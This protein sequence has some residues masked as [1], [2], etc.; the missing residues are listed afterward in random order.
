MHKVPAANALNSWEMSTVGHP[1]SDVCNLLMQFYTP[2]YA[3]AAPE[4]AKGFLPGRTPGLPTES[5]LLRWYTAVTGYDP[6]PDMSWGMAFNIFKLA[7][8]CQ[9]I[10]ARYARRQASSEKAK[11]H[12]ITRVPLAEFAWELAQQSGGKAK[13]GAKL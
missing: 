2:R 3:G 13:S 7:G 5:Q 9:G 1:L 12:A 4:S 8:V 10:A 11:Q 6:Q